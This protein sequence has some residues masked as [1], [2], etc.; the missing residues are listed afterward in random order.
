VDQYEKV[1]AA[2]RKAN[3]SKLKGLPVSLARDGGSL[4]ARAVFPPKTGE[5]TPRQRRLPLGLK[6]AIENLYPAAEKCREIGGDLIAGRWQ[7]PDD[8]PSEIL[9]R[10]F[11]AR[12]RENYLERNLKPGRSRADCLSFWEKD[13]GGVFG[14]LPPDKPPSL[15]EFIALTADTPPHTRTRQRYTKALA[16]IL[17]LAGIPDGQLTAMRGDYSPAVVNPRDIPSFE[18]IVNWANFLDGHWRFLYFLH[19]CFGLRGT[20]AHPENCN[21]ED[22]SKGELLVFS[23]KTKRW[24]FVPTCNEGLFQA[25]QV[26]PEWQKPLRSPLQYSNSFT[27]TLHRRGF[28]FTPYALRHYYAIETLAQGWDTSWAAKCMGHSV[29]IHQQVYWLAIDQNQARIIQQRQSQQ[30]SYMDT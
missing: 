10:D 24:R 7:W 21:L 26:A 17:K 29:A 5:L 2:I 18:D 9:N 14:K 30:K 8:K 23:G 19:A 13:F 25:L 15:T 3:D 20:E 1:D 6:A 27:N 11:I 4:C 16:G 12:H 22:L 28:P